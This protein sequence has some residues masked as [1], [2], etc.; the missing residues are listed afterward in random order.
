VAVG[1]APVTACGDSD[2]LGAAEAAEAGAEAAEAEEE[3]EEEDD[4]PPDEHPAAAATTAPAASAPAT[5]IRSEA[6][7]ISLSRPGTR[8][9]VV[10]TTRLQPCRN[11]RYHRDLIPSETTS[12]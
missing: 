4:D 6:I 8:A 3:E 1:V 11:H 2:A 5:L 10:L 7:T 9:A 12:S